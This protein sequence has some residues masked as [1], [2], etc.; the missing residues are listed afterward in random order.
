MNKNPLLKLEALGQSIWLDYIRRDLMAG[1]GLKRLIEEDGL[2]GITSN[3][4]V[5]EKAIV[6]SGLYDGEIRSL[7]QKGSTAQQT[8]ESLSQDD[9]RHAADVFLP[10]YARTKGKDGYVSLEVDPHLAHDTEGT[11]AEARRLWAV[12][13]RPN[14]MIKV[15]ATKEGLPAI[16]RL[17]GEGINVNVT[18]IFGQNQYRDVAQA[19]LAGLG[20]RQKWGKPLGTLASVASFFVGRIDS[21]VDPMLEKIIFLDVGGA[22]HAPAARGKTGIACAKKAYEI[23]KEVFGNGKFKKFAAKGAQVQRL[24]WA[25]TGVKDTAESDVKYVEALIAPETVNTIPLATFD[26]YRDHG[27][28]KVRL[29]QETLEA[30]R[31]MELLQELGIDMDALTQQLENEAVEKLCLSF[32]TLLDVL[33]QRAS[34]LAEELAEETVSPLVI[35]AVSL[36]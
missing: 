28:P 12:L 20:D 3:P 10:V 25:S 5:F 16:R 34:P 36:Q 22:E 1:G 18:M 13:A 19:Y 35:P 15:P 7:A 17:L 2:R 9:V 8:Y 30:R 4:S 26:A 31:L 6:E 27:K 33:A 29:E 32:D 23:F 21:L 24:L 11:I 14:V